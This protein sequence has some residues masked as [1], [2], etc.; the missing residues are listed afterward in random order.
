MEEDKSIIA[1][2][3]WVESI[4]VGLNLCPFA[5]REMQQDSIRY[6]LTEASS[7]ERLLVTLEAELNLL[8][9]DES[10]ET[11]LLIHP[12]VLQDFFDFNEFLNLAD[13]LL[14]TMNLEGVYQIAS[15]HPQY[16]FAG[17]DTDDVENYTN[18][19]PYPMLHIIREASL[20]HAVAGFPDVNKISA[21]N[22]ALMKELG[23]ARIQAMLQDCFK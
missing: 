10:I 15:F 19:S 5:E 17:T 23:S 4:V 21:R 22:I 11:T 13:R 2:R 9:G 1:V 3:Q 18:R 12:Q 14:V 7:E 20:E 6:S 8:N 16:Q